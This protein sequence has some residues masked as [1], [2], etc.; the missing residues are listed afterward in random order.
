MTDLASACIHIMNLNKKSYYKNIGSF[1]T[2]INVGSGEE[3]SIK[4]LAELIKKVIGYNGKIKFDPS[5]SDGTLT[6]LMNNSRIK[7]LNW[8]NNINLEDGIKKV[9]SQFEKENNSK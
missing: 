7:K 1:S 2:H 5:K 4:K 6:K 9:Y 8:K 3:I